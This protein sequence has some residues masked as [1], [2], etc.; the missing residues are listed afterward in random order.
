MHDNGENLMKWYGINDLLSKLLDR[1]EQDRDLGLG[2]ITFE[3]IWLVTKLLLLFATLITIF[4]MLLAVFI[5]VAL[6]K[7]LC[8]A[9][10]LL[11]SLTHY[12]S[13]VRQNRKDLKN[14]LNRRTPT[15]LGYGIPL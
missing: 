1:L 12:L 10:M 6:E 7:P 3:T 15:R 5:L 2:R 14:S 4:P 13:G 8:F 11:G 9:L